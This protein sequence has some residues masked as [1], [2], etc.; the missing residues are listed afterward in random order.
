MKV[1]TNLYL[2]G[3]YLSSRIILIYDQLID[4]EMNEFDSEKY[5]KLL[6]QLKELI[7]KE[8][9]AYRELTLKE[10]NFYLSK[11]EEED[12]ENVNLDRY[13]NKLENRKE[14][15]TGDFKLDEDT[16]SY[17]VLD[18]L[19][20]IETLKKLKDLI[21]NTETDNEEEE[22]EKDEFYSYFLANRY[23]YL[24][25]NGFLEKLSLSCGFDLD[26][27]LKIDLP[28]I[29]AEVGFEY[30]MVKVFQ[31]RYEIK[32]LY[33]I[34]ELNALY[35]TPD[36]ELHDEYEKPFMILLISSEISS[37][38]D[39]LDKKSLLC[40]SDFLNNIKKY[41]NFSHIEEMIKKKIK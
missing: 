31:K 33:D 1:K 22:E 13:A 40:V 16:L 34:N 27:I 19:I 24:I 12:Y 41:G 11:I 4:T 32:C 25:A 35:E 10:V 2:P 6:G 36:S 30:D 20:T 9:K 7:I 39:I 14:I 28:M 29:E 26:K 37:L 5:N 17:S 8:D 15:L 23:D 21:L 3:F 38:I 18:S